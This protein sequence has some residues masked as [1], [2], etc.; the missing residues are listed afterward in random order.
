MARRKLLGHLQTKIPATLRDI[1]VREKDLEFLPVFHRVARA[2]AWEQVAVVVS[3]AGC[4]RNNMIHGEVEWMALIFDYA[5]MSAIKAEAA[6]L[7]I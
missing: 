1:S 6:R 2:A 5:S 4:L 3:S 7:G